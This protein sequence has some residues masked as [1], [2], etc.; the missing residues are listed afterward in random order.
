MALDKGVFITFEGGEGAGKS[1]QIRLLNEWIK[2]R[3]YKTLVTREP[4]GTKGAE[5]IRE[6]IVTGS[7]NRWSGTTETLLLSAARSDHLEKTIRPAL[8]SGTW[9]L[10]DRFSDSTRAYQGARGVKPDMIERLDELVVGSTQ[11]D[12]T[13]LFDMPVAQGMERAKKRAQKAGESD[14]RFEQMDLFFHEDLRQRFLDLEKNN[15]RIVR[16]DASGD[17]GEVATRVRNVVFDRFGV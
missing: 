11:P 7:S 14:Q 5:D 10:C 4:G 1:T 15:Q 17:I 8:S 3:G 2:E 9:V 6:L 12:L 16:I 13:L